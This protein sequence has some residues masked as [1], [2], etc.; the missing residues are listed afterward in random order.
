M[1]ETPQS[2]HKRHALNIVAQLPDNAQD[3]ALVLTLAQHLF[4]TFLQEAPQSATNGLG[5]V[6]ALWGS[7]QPPI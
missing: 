4:T 3:A 6:I 5:K 2:W 1:P 7:V